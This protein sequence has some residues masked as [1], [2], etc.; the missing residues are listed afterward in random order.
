[1]TLLIRARLTLWRD[2]GGN[3]LQIISNM[4]LFCISQCFT[5]ETGVTRNIQMYKK[6]LQWSPSESDEEELRVSACWR[7]KVHCSVPCKSI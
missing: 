6:G 3:G 5:G 4:L 7:P 2:R 1:M